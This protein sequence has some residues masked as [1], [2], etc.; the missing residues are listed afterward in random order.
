MEKIHVFKTGTSFCILIHL[1]KMVTKQREAETF[2]PAGGL[3]SGWSIHAFTIPF[4]IILCGAGMPAAHNQPYTG[5][6]FLAFSSC[7]NKTRIKN[8]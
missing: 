3:S 4:I 7:I 1:R 5:K 6:P 8:Q 2:N